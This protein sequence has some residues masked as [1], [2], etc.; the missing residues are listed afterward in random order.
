MAGIFL[1]ELLGCNKIFPVAAVVDYIKNGDCGQTLVNNIKNKIIFGCMYP[2]LV[3]FIGL[4]IYKGIAIGHVF[5]RSYTCQ[6]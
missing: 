1:C 4:V 3:A 2:D 6:Y 5:Q